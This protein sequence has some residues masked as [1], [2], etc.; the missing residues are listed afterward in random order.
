[1][2]EVAIFIYG[3][4][5]FAI[6]AGACS[7]IGYGIVTERRDRLQLDAEAEAAGAGAVEVATGESGRTSALAGRPEGTRP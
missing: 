2:N 6:V 5:V 1:M 7:L 3:I 4:V